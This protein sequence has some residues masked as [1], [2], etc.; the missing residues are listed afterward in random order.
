M[1]QLYLNKP[2]R[3]FLAGEISECFCHQE[4]WSDHQKVVIVINPCELSYGI[5]HL[6]IK[7]LMTA[8]DAYQAHYTLRATVRSPRYEN[9][10]LDFPTDHSAYLI[11][12]SDFHFEIPARMLD[13]RSSTNTTLKVSLATQGTDVAVVSLHKGNESGC[14][15]Y[16]SIA[17][18]STKENIVTGQ[19]PYCEFEIDWCKLA[20]S[21]AGDYYLAV[22]PEKSIDLYNP[23]PYTVFA[24]VR[25]SSPTLV[26]LTPSAGC[27]AQTTTDFS[28]LNGRTQHF[29][30][31]PPRELTDSEVIEVTISNIKNGNLQ[32]NSNS[33]GFATSQCR[34][35]EPI[36]CTEAASN[37]ILRL[38]CAKKIDYISVKV[39]AK[40]GNVPVDFSISSCFSKFS[41]LAFNTLSR[42]VRL[43]PGGSES[44]VVSL[45]SIVPTQVPTILIKV[46]PAQIDVPLTL[47]FSQGRCS[48]CSDF[49]K[50]SRCGGGVCWLAIHFWALP[51]NWATA[52]WYIQVDNVDK[53]KN[54]DFTVSIFSSPA[55]NP[56]VS[57]TTGSRTNVT[58]VPGTWS[59]LEW[60]IGATEASR[61]TGIASGRVTTTITAPTPVP[62]ALLH[63][64]TFF[65]T[66]TPIQP[67]ANP[68]LVA[69]GGGAGGALGIYNVAQCCL[70]AGRWYAYVWNGNPAITWTVGVTPTIQWATR[71]IAADLGTAKTVTVAKGTTVTDVYVKF[72]GYP[73]DTTDPGTVLQFSVQPADALTSP[74]TIYRNVNSPA[75]PKGVNSCTTYRTVSPSATL[76][77]SILACAASPLD[78]AI[79][80]IGLTSPSVDRTYQV[81]VSTVLPNTLTV[82]PR[83]DDVWSANITS[84]LDVSRQSKV[85]ILDSLRVYGIRLTAQVEITSGTGT[86]VLHW[87]F[88]AAAGPYSASNPCSRSL[89]SATARKTDAV[90]T[91]ASI[92]L[93]R[94]LEDVKAIYLGTTVTSG[95]PVYRVRVSSTNLFPGDRTRVVTLAEPSTTVSDAGP[96]KQHLIKF[97]LPG[98]TPTSTNYVKFTVN[99]IKWVS[100]PGNVTITWGQLG[101][102]SFVS[103]ALCSRAGDSCV[104]IAYP[105]EINALAEFSFHVS[106]SQ[107]GSYTTLISLEGST[108]VISDIKIGEERQVLL[109]TNSLRFFSIDLRKAV[110]GLGMSDQLL[111][112]TTGISCGRAVAWINRANGASPSCNLNSKGA[113]TCST[114]DCTLFKISACDL[115]TQDIGGIYQV[116]V[117][118]LEQYDTKGTIKFRLKVSLVKGALSNTTVVTF[119]GTEEHR[120]LARGYDLLKSNPVTEALSTKQCTPEILPQF[121]SCCGLAKS[122]NL[123]HAW[124]TDSVHYEYVIVGGHHLGYGAR[125]DVGVFREV[126]SAT[127]VFTTDYPRVCTDSY[128]GIKTCTATPNRPCTFDVDPCI[129]S[130][131][132]IWIWVNPDSVKWVSSTTGPSVTPGDLTYEVAWIRPWVKEFSLFEVTPPGNRSSYYSL[133]HPFWLLPGEKEYIQIAHP[134]DYLEAPNYHVHVSVEKVFGGAIEIVQ[135]NAWTPCSTGDCLVQECHTVFDEDE[136]TQKAPACRCENLNRVYIAPCFGPEEKTE[137]YDDDGA[138]HIMIKAVGVTDLLNPKPITGRVKF[139]FWEMEEAI[140]KDRCEV[141]LTGRSRFFS[142]NGTL[143]VNQ[144]WKFTLTDMQQDA[145]SLRLSL[146]EGKIAL[147]HVSCAERS[148][149]QAVGDTCTLFFRGT[150]RQIP[151]VSVYGEQFGTQVAGLHHFYLT[152]EMITPEV[153]TLTRGVPSVSPLLKVDKDSCV[154]AVAPQYYLYRTQGN[155]DYL[156]VV[157][158]A[159]NARAWIHR[160]HLVHGWGEWICDGRQTGGICETVIA[161]DYRR[162]SEV[163]YIHVEGSSHEITIYES[164]IQ[165]TPVRFGTTLGSSKLLSESSVFAFRLTNV[166]LPANNDPTRDLVISLTGSIGTS[167]LS[168]DKPGDPSCRIPQ[169]SLASPTAA[170]DLVNIIPSCLLP[171]GLT[172]DIYANV[173]PSRSL[174]DNSCPSRE[175]SISSNFISSNFGITPANSFSNV[176]NV[177]YVVRPTLFGVK[178]QHRV[179]LGSLGDNDVIVTRITNANMPLSHTVWKTN[180]DNVPRGY[181]SSL[182]P[183]SSLIP[184][185]SL[186]LP[187]F[188]SPSIIPNG[189]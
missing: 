140:Q 60:V 93:P 76:Y 30:I 24:G 153:F 29:T 169:T 150:D 127:V 88:D 104:T 178:A 175:F 81:L 91:V 46:Q 189:R 70:S 131:R 95:S 82:R 53:V 42:P 83:E 85:E 145:G 21:G 63:G 130:T 75:G 134:T 129:R 27:G 139:S 51:E 114:G 2:E 65:V 102:C 156:S 151:K 5:Y 155:A 112:Q 66:N 61:D 4:K 11:Q 58:A 87:N 86:V 120:L 182:F 84:P 179:D 13:G 122:A 103:D 108:Q 9:F 19:R 149:C 89:G 33:G 78:P 96:S 132:Q 133:Y 144:I 158:A 54:L 188:F 10:L 171:A 3:P 6:S 7:T 92:S 187:S 38:S 162:T 55:T 107:Q 44:F 172:R 167:W 147:P 36:R 146:N 79:Y 73:L 14:G 74:V 62:S 16:N 123:T 106:L 184:P 185:S 152:A 23:I 154:K 35:A 163:F 32:V 111:I 180:Y 100:T 135:E 37:C 160:G 148:F 142:P 39:A 90:T 48:A 113:Q 117:R 50:V 40:K 136:C 25:A 186:P 31:T 28:M 124:V 45:S 137:K 176:T 64:V 128:T 174:G 59:V 97:Q 109:E 18:C 177:M 125:I 105:C 17:Q 94:C 26:T 101:S 49:V 173:A 115:M 168:Y 56:T 98:A 143:G 110:A 181:V 138:D 22:Y 157:L 34:F 15:C 116:T 57:M 20:P 99:N 69:A 161:C 71:H 164:T 170:A 165:V 159:P 183:P 126:A 67:T 141:V 118:G 43:A 1:I 12:R 41:D 119:L 80:W 47:T 8:Y 77:R 121:A 68:A 166:A 72:P 52:N